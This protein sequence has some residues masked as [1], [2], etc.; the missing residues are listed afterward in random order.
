MV[1]PNPFAA[2]EVTVPQSNGVETAPA[3]EAQVPTAATQPE[4][5]P[6]PS[7]Q[8]APPQFNPQ[9]FAAP[10]VP[11][12]PT[13]P[14]APTPMQGYQQPTQS[15]LAAAPAPS[16][17]VI[18]SQPPLPGSVPS[19]FFEVDLA[20]VESNALIAEGTYA[21]YLDNIEAATS[22]AGNP[23]WVW[24]FRIF[25]HPQYNGRQLRIWT[26]LTAEAMF[27]VKETCEA[28]GLVGD[29]PRFTLQDIR[30]IVVFGQVV[31]EEFDNRVRNTL[32]RVWAPGP[33]AGGPGQ[34]YNPQQAGLPGR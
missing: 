16:P 10:Q 11:P 34:K 27:K 29:K 18:P 21:L 25:N 13:M 32:A 3:A 5:Q 2:P 28:I 22:N 31:H 1:A 14:Q 23:M 7:T 12:P 19:A 17:M 26:A 9:A 4:A 15:P 20:G 33:E 8:P 30:Y 6:Q 24:F